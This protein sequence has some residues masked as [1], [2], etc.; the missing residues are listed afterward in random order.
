MKTF[1]KTMITIGLIGAGLTSYV[2]L[3]KNGNKQ[4]SKMIKN[5][6][7]NKINNNKNLSN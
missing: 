1:S 4:F 3:K 7:N 5:F 6:N 2:M